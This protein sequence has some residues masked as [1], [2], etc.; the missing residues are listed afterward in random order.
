MHRFQ[1]RQE[2]S[3]EIP[4]NIA[5]FLVILLFEDRIRFHSDG[6]HCELPVEV[7][8]CIVIRVCSVATRAGEQLLDPSEDDAMMWIRSHLTNTVAATHRSTSGANLRGAKW[9]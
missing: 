3:L 5:L 1:L 4:N 2:T 7:D 8:R 6:A 9:M